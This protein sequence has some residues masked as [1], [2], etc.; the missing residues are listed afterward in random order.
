MSCTDY[1]CNGRILG[2]W[3]RVP[4]NG[5]M[6]PRWVLWAATCDVTC[7]GVTTGMDLMAPERGMQA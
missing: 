3:L 1:G 7:D 5:R 6:G 2:G 4:T